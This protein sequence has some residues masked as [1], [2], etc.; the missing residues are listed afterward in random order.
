MM[1][2]AFFKSLIWQ[3][4]V[5]G[6][7]YVLL[8]LEKETLTLDYYKNQESFG[9][10]CKKCVAAVTASAEEF[11]NRT[12]AKN[13]N[14]DFEARFTKQEPVEARPISETRPTTEVSTIIG[15]VVPLK[16]DR[17]LLGYILLSILTCG[18]YGYYFIYSVAKDVNVACEGDGVKTG[19]LA[20]F[21]ILSI[22]T[23]G[24]Y[25]LIWQYS[26][27]NRLASN[28][29]RYGLNFQENGT[30]VLLWYIFGSLICGIGPFIAMNIII[31]NT[32][33]ICMAYNAHHGLLKTK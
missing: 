23:C 21:I 28:A 6:I 17:G 27:A 16:T 31:K 33:S 13:T 19:G 4:L 10:Y 12:S 29:T 22:L 24:I 25:S 32:N 2:G 8:S 7:V 20:K 1:F 18:I 3:A 26:L 30:S 5:C 14:T 15:K 11:M 9:Q